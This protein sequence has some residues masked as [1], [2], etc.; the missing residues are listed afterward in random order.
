MLT[1]AK[2]ERTGKLIEIVDGFLI[3]DASTGEWQF[4]SFKAPEQVYDYHI[5]VRDLVRDPTEFFD[6]MAHLDEKTWFRPDKFIACFSRL[7]EANSR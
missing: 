5:A 4:V 6:W 3:A 2:C 7:R 1:K